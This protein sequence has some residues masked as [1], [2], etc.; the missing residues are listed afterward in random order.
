MSK[1]E[2]GRESLSSAE[3]GLVAEA[4]SRLGEARHRINMLGASLAVLAASARRLGSGNVGD[5]EADDERAD[6]SIGLGTLLDLTGREAFAIANAVDEVC[7]FLP[8][9]ADAR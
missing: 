3:V 7:L 6:Q 8:A 1:Q 2:A 9:K 4:H 5:V